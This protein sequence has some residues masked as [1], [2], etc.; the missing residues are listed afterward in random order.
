MSD[1]L[2]NALQ[3]AKDVASR[4]IKTGELKAT[5]DVLETRLKICLSCEE[6]KY[7]TPMKTAGFA[8]CGACKC[9]MLI[10]ISLAASKCPLKPNPK[11]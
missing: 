9:M 4:L 11:W 10:K 5:D 3:T 1:I 7:Y 8:T 2:K 6:L